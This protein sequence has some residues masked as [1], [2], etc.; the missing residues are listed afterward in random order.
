MP[1]AARERRDVR[2][3]GEAGAL[4]K[5]MSGRRADR[6]ADRRTVGQTVGQTIAPG[7]NTKYTHVC[8]YICIFPGGFSTRS[9]HF[10]SFDF[11]GK[12]HLAVIENCIC[13]STEEI[14]EFT[15]IRITV[16]MLKC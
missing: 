12:L 14:A 8:M 4:K 9:F 16:K 3:G 10:I 13:T 1:R 2:M 15:E 6:Q 11:S 5:G 7:S